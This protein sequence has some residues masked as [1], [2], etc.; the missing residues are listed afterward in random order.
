M[1]SLKAAFISFCLRNSLNPI[2]CLPFFFFLLRS[3]S[4]ILKMPYKEL[5]DRPALLS[6]D[7]PVNP[8][9]AKPV[10]PSLFPPQ[11]KRQV[12]SSCG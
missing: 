7:P 6:S 1:A 9:F 11:P 5:T 4:A 12:G 2:Y 8:R 3:V 10:D